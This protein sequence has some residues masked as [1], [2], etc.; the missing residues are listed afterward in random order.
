MSHH[1][2]HSD[3]PTSHQPDEP[4]RATQR[5]RWLSST[6]AL[7]LIFVLAATVAGCTIGT[8]NSSTSTSPQG[9]AATVA[10]PPSA[11][12]LQQTV[13]NVI[14]TVQPSVV[15]VLSQGSQGSAIGSGEIL[16]KDGY[17][18]TNDHVVEGFT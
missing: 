16:T 17:I 12:D 6:G 15:E 4:Q 2:Q 1:T 8:N 11:Q 5:I 18:I 13:V 10:V 9:A 7:S 3:D 14:R